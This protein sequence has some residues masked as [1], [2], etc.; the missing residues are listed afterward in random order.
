[1]ITTILVNGL[2]LFSF[3]ICLMF[4][5]GDVDKA[6][7]TPT[8]YPIIEVVFEATKS[9]AATTMMMCFIIF[10]GILALFSTL[11]SVSRLVWAFAR[12]RGLPFSDF[13]AYV[14]SQPRT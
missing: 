11:A 2:L 8:G 4:T 3:M 10:T 6:L 14:S 5:L 12:D 13:F 9:H 1:M 7:N